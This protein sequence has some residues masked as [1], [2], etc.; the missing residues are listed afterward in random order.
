ME[1][2]MKTAVLAIPELAG[3]R[4]AA[5]NLIE[6]TAPSGAEIVL[7]FTDSRVAGQGF[8]DEL[9][10]QLTDQRG[11]RIRELRGASDRTTEYIERALWLRSL[12]G[13]PGP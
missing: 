4:W 6:A 12:P 11:I 1:G 10:T 2:T 8:C 3:T 5:Q 13:I 9:V 7:D